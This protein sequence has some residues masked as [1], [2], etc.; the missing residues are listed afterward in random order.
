MT[1][2]GDP[3][4]PGDGPAVAADP[5]ARPVGSAVAEAI[6]VMDTLRR[7]GR[8][9]SG[10]THASLRPYLIE[11]TYE[12]LDAIDSGDAAELRDELGDLL[13]QVLFH[14]RI[15]QDARSFDID[16]VAAALVAKLRRRSPLLTTPDLTMDIADQESAWQAAKAVEK[17]GRRS[18]VDGIALGLPAL[19]LAGKVL[20]RAAGA[21]LPADLVP[22]SITRIALP[23]DGEGD[24]E[25]ELRRR[26]LAF[27]ERIRAA[28]RAAVDAGIEPGEMTAETWRLYWPA[29]RSNGVATDVIDGDGDVTNDATEG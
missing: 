16:D 14:A 28:E 29:G 24:A 8:W 17:P 12:V 25:G 23:A 20:G 5:A 1:A 15:A 27:A 19:A 3:T 22:E 18:C 11:E 4:L 2:Q 6:E 7:L 26:V 10:Q 13:L 9:E 21:G